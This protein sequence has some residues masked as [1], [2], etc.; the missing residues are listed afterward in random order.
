MSD[1]QWSRLS[2]PRNWISL[3]ELVLSVLQCEMRLLHYQVIAAYKQYD[4]AKL[5]VDNIAHWGTQ[6]PLFGGMVG[7][8][9]NKAFAL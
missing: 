9:L 3:Q 7:G 4:R 2:A 8:L 6:V 5:R 1:D